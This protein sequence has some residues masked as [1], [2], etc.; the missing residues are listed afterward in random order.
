MAREPRASG[1]EDFGSVGRQP[2]MAW[3]FVPKIPDENRAGRLDIV[4]FNGPGALA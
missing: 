3:A 2:F 4:H 1:L